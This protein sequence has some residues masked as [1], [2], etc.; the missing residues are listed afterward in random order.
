MKKILV[1]TKNRNKVREIGEILGDLDVEFVPLPDDVAEVVEDGKTFLDNAL[2]KAREYSAACGGCATLAED[3]GLEVFSLDGEPGVFSA[4]YAGEKAGAE[5]NNSLLLSRLAGVPAEGRGA[6][7]VCVAV[8]VEGGTE[9]IFE[10]EVRGR[11]AEAASGRTGFGYD[12][13]FIPEW[14]EK[15]FA[16]MS[17]EEKNAISHRRRALEKF[18]SFL[19]DRSTSP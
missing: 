5:E 7:F 18:A 19:A 8:Y 17:G 3:S 15:T 9:K 13:V 12:P 16:E 14:Y 10:G 1:A 6:R 11:I 2:K 4:R